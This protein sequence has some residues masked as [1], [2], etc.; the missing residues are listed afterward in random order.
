[1]YNRNMEGIKRLKKQK[2][3]HRPHKSSPQNKT[4]F[5]LEPLGDISLGVLTKD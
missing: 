3:K 2:N 4:S 1:L 5:M